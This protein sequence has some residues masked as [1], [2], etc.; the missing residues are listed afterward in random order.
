MATLSASVAL[1][2]ANPSVWYGV[3]DSHSSTHITIKAGL[4]SATYGGNF[5]YDDFGNVFGQLASYQT[6][7]NGKT[8]LSVTGLNLDA[9]QVMSMV[10]DGNI[11]GLYQIALAGKDKMTGSA[12]ADVLL[13]FGNND[14]LIGNA[15]N[16]T[17][18][19]GSGNDTIDG[20]SGVDRLYGGGGNDTFVRGVGDVISEDVGAGRDIVRSSTSYALAANLEALT[21]TGSSAINGAG[22]SLANSIIGN[23][24]SNVLSGNGGNDYLYAG[25]G[26]D[27][28]SGG[29]GGDKL[30]GG[31]DGLADAFVFTSASHSAVGAGRDVVYNFTRGAD[32]IDLHTIDAVA[33]TASTNE[34]FLFSGKTAQA[35]SVWFAVAGANVVVKGDIS[36]DKVADFEIQVNGLSTL[37]ALDFLL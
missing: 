12:Y 23:S 35:H 20:G 37:N 10:D 15:G 16:D 18:Y 14:S 2:M 19:G 7:Y 9:Y 4:L 21:L 36:G 1:D 22:N 24:A 28:L 11:A 29:S 31:T 13:G 33:S 32:D 30:Y 27:T 17:L 3:L 26:K 34:A 25:G 5:S 6:F 8:Q